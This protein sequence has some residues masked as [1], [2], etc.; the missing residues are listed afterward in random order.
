MMRRSL[1]FVV[2]LF[3]FL[4]TA[5]GLNQSNILE[6]ELGL[7]SIQ[8]LEELQEK[9]S[10]SSNLYLWDR[11]TW[12]SMTG[13]WAEDA[14]LGG[15]AT[16]E[17]TAKSSDDYTSTN[18]QVEGVDE[19]DL[20]KTDG[21]RIYSIS[22]YTLKVVE[23]NQGHMEVKLVDKLYENNQT[24]SYYYNNYISDLYLTNRYFVI[25]YN[26]YPNFYL[27]DELTVNPYRYEIST[28]VRIY[29]IETLAIVEEYKVSGRQVTSRLIDDNLYLILSYVDQRVD[30]EVRPWVKE[31]DEVVYTSL[32]DIK[33]LPNTD[34]QAFTVIT[35]IAL[36]DEIS[37]E[38]DVL[39]GPSY[40][41]QVYVNHNAIYLTTYQY[42]RTLL[43]DYQNTGLLVSYLFN[44]SGSVYYGGS[45]VFLGNVIDQFSM[46]EY[47]GY[48]RSV[49]TTGFR[50]TAVNRLYVFER[51]IVDNQYYLNV[52]GKIEK[53]LGKPGE[54][55]RSARFNE[56]QATIVTFLQ[57]DPLYVVDISDPTNPT[58]VGELEILGFSVYQH[59]WK[60]NYVIGLGYDASETGRV[61][62][63]K[64]SLFDIS[65]PNNPL[66]VGQ[67]LVFPYQESWI[68]TNALYNH[69]DLFIDPSH[70][71]IGMTF[72]SSYWTTGNYYNAYSE[73]VMF[74]V[75]LDR[76]IPINILQTVNHFDYGRTPEDDADLTRFY[77]DYSYVIDRAVRIGDYLYVI[78]GNLMTSHQLGDDFAPVEVLP[79]N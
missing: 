66:E 5:C 39:L 65:D 13:D 16:N 10:E 52:V 3:S 59:P 25:I 19:G 40:W 53:G 54:T 26:V 46:D 42:E 60:D 48:M 70:D 72:Q 74:D 73:F 62:G 63:L 51:Q 41:N 67:S 47:D 43:G 31:G 69:K 12:S 75:D 18:L 33:Y 76:E 61:T 58:I 22:N 24:N 15:V 1:L 17:S 32:N 27:E 71:C 64:L 35:K 68:Y 2:L 36:L 55:I 11:F 7:S 38:T 6:R 77:W 14:S 57:A 37:I 45:G 4:L 23:V 29:D 78:S 44:E 28:S 56:D 34:Y 49:T 8:T 20:V 79:F 21:N 9:M 30:T 50:D